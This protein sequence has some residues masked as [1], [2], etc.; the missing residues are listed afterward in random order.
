MGSTS[1]YIVSQDPFL[2]LFFSVC[3]NAGRTNLQGIAFNKKWP[4]QEMSYEGKQFLELH[5]GDIRAN[6]QS[7][8]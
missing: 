4:L 7:F 8:L 1:S 6:R 3:L 2:G 5:M